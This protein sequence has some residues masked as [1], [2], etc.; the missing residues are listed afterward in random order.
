MTGGSFGALDEV[1]NLVAERAYGGLDPAQAV[2]LADGAAEQAVAGAST[3][4]EPIDGAAVFSEIM[5]SYVAQRYPAMARGAAVACM[6]VD[7]V[8]D[9]RHIGRMV[10]ELGVSDGELGDAVFA[11]QIGDESPMNKIRERFYFG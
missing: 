7:Q 10:D 5:D 3:P 8:C 2:S 9:T 4:D 1:S 11:S 6:R